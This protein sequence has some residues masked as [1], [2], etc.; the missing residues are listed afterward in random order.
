MLFMVVVSVIIDLCYCRIS[1]CMVL[2]LWFVLLL[3]FW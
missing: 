3:L 1:Y 2:E